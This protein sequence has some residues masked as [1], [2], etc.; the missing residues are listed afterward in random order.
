ML[1]LSKSLFDPQTE[2]LLSALGPVELRQWLLI[3]EPRQHVG[4]EI[5]AL[6]LSGRVG[7][8]TYETMCLGTAN[9]LSQALS[10]T[11]C[12]QAAWTSAWSTSVTVSAWPSNASYWT[13]SMTWR[14][15]ARKYLSLVCSGFGVQGFRQEFTGP[16]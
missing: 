2:T 13:C 15:N 6:Q 1:L 16:T 8:M 3:R 14:P 12:T 4:L 10:F 9:G 5:P 7:G 11:C